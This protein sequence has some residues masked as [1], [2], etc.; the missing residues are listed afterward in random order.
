MNE[1]ANE[2]DQATRTEPYRP[3]LKVNYQEQVVPRL[4]ERFGL[5]NPLAAPRLTKI[6]LNMGVGEAVEDPNALT[7]AVATL[8]A[9]S[10][11]QP[12]VTRARA[13]LPGTVPGLL[14]RRGQL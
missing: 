8:R 3:R 6:V 1:S 4:M 11:Q 10:G 13:G 14:R 9:I 2:T 12:V 5:K 7:D